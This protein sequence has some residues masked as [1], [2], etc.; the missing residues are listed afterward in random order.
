MVLDDTKHCA[1][2]GAQCLPKE[3]RQH[4]MQFSRFVAYKLHLHSDSFYRAYIQGTHSFSSFRCYFRH[5]A[6]LKLF[7]QVQPSTRAQPHATQLSYTDDKW[8]TYTVA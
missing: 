2:F 7:E 6:S 1:L 8:T 5:R 3:Q 4:Q